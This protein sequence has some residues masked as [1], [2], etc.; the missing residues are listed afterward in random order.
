M[1]GGR[2]RSND[3]ILD[4]VP[5]NLM[6]YGVVS[7]IVSNEAAQEFEL[8][9]SVP[10]AEFG[11]TMASTVNMVTR[12]GSNGFHGAFYE[13]FRNNAMDANNTFNKRGNAPRGVLR[14]NQFGGSLGGPIVRNKHFFLR[15]YRT[16]AHH[17]RGRI[18]TRQR[19]HSRR[20]TGPREL[21]LWK[22]RPTDY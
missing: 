7:F 17:R 15:Q 22:R 5:M 6:Q 8:K 13:F 16:D 20:E 4:G 11:R 10:Q 21:Q 3:F 19:P 2:A 9:T 12:S 1:N 18:K 14:Q